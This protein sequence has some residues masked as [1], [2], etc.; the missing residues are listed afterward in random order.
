MII[1]PSSTLCAFSLGGKDPKSYADF[2]GLVAQVTARV[3]GDAPGVQE[4]ALQCRDRYLFAAVA[5]ASIALGVELT[6]CGTQGDDTR[7]TL[8]WNQPGGAHGALDLAQLEAKEPARAGALELHVTT[9][10]P[11]LK[12]TTSGS[13]GAPT[14]WEK[15]P[16]QLF[17][18][19]E[20]HRR[21]FSLG[22]DARMGLTVLPEHIYGLLFGILLPIV[23]G[24]SFCRET[25]QHA[26]SIL[27][28]TSD[29]QIS[30]LVTVPA[31]ARAILG[32]L[33]AH[34]G[35]T[36]GPTVTTMVSSGAR[37]HPALATALAQR[38]VRVVD[39]LGSTETG[40]IA[41]REPSQGELYL[42]LAGVQV[43]ETPE[44]CLVLRSPFLPPMAGPFESEDRIALEGKGFRYLGRRDRVVKVGGLRVSLDELTTTVCTIPG[45]SEA[46]AFAKE[47]LD[48]DDLR[49][50]T[51]WLVV[52]TDALDRITLWRELRGRLTS[53]SMPRQVR[54][55][56]RAPLDE[57]GKVS[58]A[59]LE[60]LFDDAPEHPDGSVVERAVTLPPVRAPTCQGH[61]DGEPIG[62]AFPVRF[63]TGRSPA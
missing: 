59:Q 56:E 7:S 6:I 30:H 50:S 57:R 58:F 34:P 63:P 36:F 12:L 25:P 17:S 44:G 19:A 21:W 53:S 23:S 42:P 10:E 24:A 48:P 29:H 38:G 51:I 13:Q 52:V 41:W 54:I 40:G 35:T 22:P 46:F 20:T 8:S 47:E 49:G 39:I 5:F 60:A 27:A 62:S 33:E 3:Q 55:V 15:S 37:L 45:V 61:F 18:E 32:D 43:E 26:A 31:H 11:W 1:V 14:S 28:M 4:F 9:D 16:R 2:L